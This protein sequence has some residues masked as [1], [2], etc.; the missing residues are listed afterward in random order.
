M[1]LIHNATYLHFYWRCAYQHSGMLVT[2]WL[3][4]CI[5]VRVWTASGLNCDALGMV[6]N[7][8]GEVCTLHA[9]YSREKTSMRV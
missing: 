7:C 2:V 6:A 1:I 4:R 5:R 9:L 8:D 3:R